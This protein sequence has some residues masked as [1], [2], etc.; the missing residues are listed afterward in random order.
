[1]DLSSFFIGFSCLPIN[2]KV[3]GTIPQSVNTLLPFFQCLCD[4]QPLYPLFLQVVLFRDSENHS[5]SVTWTIIHLFKYEVI[6]F[7]H[8]RPLLLLSSAKN[9]GLCSH[10]IN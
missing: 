10:Y 1:M 5:Y 4:A 9:P 2:V 8:I 6:T 3:R 7:P